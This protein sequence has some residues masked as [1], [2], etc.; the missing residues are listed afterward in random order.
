M[1]AA[2]AAYPRMANYAFDVGDV[3]WTVLD[4]NPYADW[5]DPA[6]RGWLERDLAAARGAAWRIVAFHQPPFHSSKSHYDEQRTRLLAPVFEQYG[7][8]LVISGHIHNYQRSYPLRFVPEKGDDGRAID[9]E[10]RVKGRWTLD[11]AYDGKS[12]TKPEGIIYLVTGGGGARLYNTDQSGD[13]SSWQE[14]TAKFV[15]NTHSLT[16]VDVD[17]AKLSVKQVSAAGDVVDQFLI[18]K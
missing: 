17:A 4:T 11:T 5:S 15:S 13:S 10:G 16:V 8:D 14:Y 7:V 12:R 3:H 6:L 18:T 9:P 1:K 2:G